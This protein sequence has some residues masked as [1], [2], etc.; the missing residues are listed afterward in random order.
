MKLRLLGVVLACL[1]GPLLIGCH[2][3]LHVTFPA[4]PAPAIVAEIDDT[5]VEPTVLVEV[6]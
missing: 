1:A 2:A 3:H 6:E 4:A 5:P